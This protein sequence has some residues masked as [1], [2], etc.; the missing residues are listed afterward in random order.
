MFYR[1]KTIVVV[2]TAI[3]AA[4][5]GSSSPLLPQSQPASERETTS[6][7][8][9]QARVSI[10]WAL[11]A[12]SVRIDVSPHDAPGASSTTIAN[13]STR[14]ESSVAIAVPAGTDTFTFTL[15]DGRG[16]QGNALGGA[17]L[18]QK[19]AAGEVNDVKVT[20]QGY[21]DG[22]RVSSSDALFHAETQPSAQSVD[23]VLA[24]KGP[25]TFA[26]VPLD[27][28]GRAI[29]GPAAPAV[30]AVSDSRAFRV[31]NV[32]RRHNTF[33]IAYLAG[34]A[35]GVETPHFVLRARG[36]AGTTFE[37]SYPVHEATL[38]LAS[39][40]SGSSAHVYRLDTEG[41]V[42]PSSGAFP[43]LQMPVALA[44]DTRDQ[45]LYVADAM[46]GKIL[47]YDIN[48]NAARG[49]SSPA[50]PGI[51]GVAFS[52]HAKRVYAATSANGGAVA[53][54][55]MTGA[56]VTTAGF[57]G[58]KSAPVGIADTA[59]D[60][61]IGV[62][63]AGNPGYVGVY[64]LDG[65]PYPQDSWWLNDCAG[66]PLEPYGISTAP[67][68]AQAASSYGDAFWITG[69]WNSASFSDEIV[70]YYWIDGPAAGW[71]PPGEA[72]FF[73]PSLLEGG[74]A[75]NGEFYPDK[76]LSHPTSVATNPATDDFYV[77]NGTGGATDGG[78]FGLQCGAGC[79]VGGQPSGIRTP[80]ESP[81]I[82]A[83]RS[84]P[85]FSAV[86]FPY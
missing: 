30:T 53:V 86:V 63:E 52:P 59:T 83:P 85:N 10:H 17:T 39:G 14:N 47:A 37:E 57:T 75:D 13:R 54:F 49:W 66:L 60:R 33:T 28:D 21:A 81:I 76:P 24:G 15:F 29:I 72:P 6:A 80:G 8:Q 68:G 26:V 44:W 77:A 22:F 16:G 55:D 36:A 3:T 9:T 4:C 19:M 27:V 43:D 70:S 64:G 82:F 25:V 5:S 51:V 61:Y 34:T 48:G 46:A 73:T 71:F 84:I 50:V 2:M 18:Q 79:P 65:T 69:N 40:G 58:I 78:L 7:T 20:L 11:D 56:P 12:H 42:Y 1:L 45:R 67:Q 35:A 38:L 41:N 74:F 31:A 62:A 32:A 23:Y